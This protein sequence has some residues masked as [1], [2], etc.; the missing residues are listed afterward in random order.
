[1]KRSSVTFIVSSRPGAC[2]SL[3]GCSRRAREAMFS[4]ARFL[5]PHCA[6]RSG[7]YEIHGRIYADSCVHRRPLLKFRRSSG[8]QN[9]IAHVNPCACSFPLPRRCY[10]VPPRGGRRG[11]LGGRAEGEHRI[12][13]LF[14]DLN[15]DIETT[16]P[17]QASAFLHGASLA[18]QRATLN[19]VACS[20]VSRDSLSDHIS[21]LFIAPRPF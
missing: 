3:D 1:V 18:L 6:A 12:P 4:V 5:I 19:E 11:C 16:L 7:S 9:P 21:P 8:L 15:R 13:G 20:N 17:E 14:D 10:R 2:A